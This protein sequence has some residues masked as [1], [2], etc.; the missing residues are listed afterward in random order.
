MTNVLFES[1]ACCLLSL[2]QS[3]FV[4]WIWCTI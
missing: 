3:E 2:I 4:D 1:S